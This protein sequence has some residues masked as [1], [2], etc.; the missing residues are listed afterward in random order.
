MKK[1]SLRQYSPIIS[2]K[3]IGEEI[4][5]NIWNLDPKDN[6]VEVD[7]SG[8]I[9]MTTYSA[10]QIFGRLYKNLGPSLFE[11]NIILINATNDVILIIK[12]GIRNAVIGI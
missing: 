1:I 2:E 11:N 7:M 12:M 3:N 9:S 6:Q 5:N 8:I 10:K 4:F